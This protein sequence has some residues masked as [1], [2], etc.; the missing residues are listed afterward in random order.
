MRI[1]VAQMGSVAGEFDETA[2][3]M[4][5]R[6]RL[7]AQRDVDLLI[8]PMT[9][10][11]GSRS[12]PTMDR[13][14]FLLDLAGCILSLAESLACPC[15][16]PVL[17]DMGGSPVPDALL[18]ADGEITPLG[19][20]ARLEAIAA[21]SASGAADPAQGGGEG[22]LPEFEFGG[23]RLGVAFTYEDLDTYVEYEYNVD[24]ILFLS[25]YGFAVDDPSSALGASL[26]EGRFLGDAEATG[27]WIVCVGSLGCYDTQV[28]C[29]SSFVL[30]PWG[31]LAAQAPS[32]EEGLIVCDVDPSAEGPLA[33]PLTPEVFDS[34]LMTW[35]ALTMGVSDAVRRQGASGACSIVTGELLP[36][37]VLTL[38]TDALG[39]TNVRVI[40]D[41]GDPD[42]M[43]LVRAL[44]IPQENVEPLGP[45]PE[46]ASI[47]EGL[48]AEASLASLAQR[49][50]CLP[51]GSSDKTAR[52]LEEP[53]SLSAARLHPLGDLYR[54]DV[55]ALAHLRNTIS[56]VIPAATLARF[57]VPA[58][59]GLDDAL[60]SD[61]SRL[62][63]VDLVLSSYVEWELPVS[64]IASQRGHA[65][66]VEAIVSRLSPKRFAGLGGGSMQPKPV[67]GSMAAGTGERTELPSFI[68]EAGQPPELPLLQ[69][70][71]VNVAKIAAC[72]ALLLSSGQAT[73][74]MPV[75]APYPMPH[76]LQMPVIQPVNGT[77]AQAGR[78][79]GNA[80]RFEKFCERIEINMP[81]GTT[82]SQ[83]DY[84]LSEL[85]RRINDAVE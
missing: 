11:C 73:T 60:S 62:E 8:F 15:V 54:S 56:P 82:D 37:V 53:P 31:E 47:P 61:E 2:R 1:A 4:V 16:V 65:E 74:G 7:A 80:A 40:V 33:D 44:R 38:A 64:D 20:A 45:A 50:G 18:I 78:K 35:G 13:E 48:L 63:F 55:V 32:L 85:M 77:A 52:A 30:A 41:E 76:P 25:G 84:L 42:A 23:A 36:A 21:A 51:L 24:V 43:A 46:G 67:T 12:V 83:V 26:T 27:A 75:P 14:G 28:F 49:T 68:E 10:L 19:L 3:R 9:T 34:P 29:G 59:E 17:T 79:P 70:I 39:P 22:A 71:A 66:L 72:S 6:S 69:Q 81:Q 5:E 57:A 58:V